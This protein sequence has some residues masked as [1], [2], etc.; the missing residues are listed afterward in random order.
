MT[1]HFLIL[2]IFFLTLSQT[3]FSQKELFDSLTTAILSQLDIIDTATVTSK[4]PKLLKNGGKNGTGLYVHH[5]T[6]DGEQQDFIGLWKFH[7]GNGQLR[8]S[9]F[10]N[11]HQITQ[12]IKK[13][14]Y[15][16]GNLMNE[17]DYGLNQNNECCNYYGKWFNKNG[18]IIREGKMQDSNMTGKWY[19]YENGEINHFIDCTNAPDKIVICKEKES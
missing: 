9:I 15:K 14:Y 10:I 4:N 1:R 8:K 17:I 12:G 13:E 19:Y 2:I 16:N 3:G 11:L 6:N 5:K 7:Y 18:Q